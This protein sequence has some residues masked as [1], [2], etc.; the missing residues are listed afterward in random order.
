MK[1]LIPLF[2]LIFVNYVSAAFVYEDYSVSTE[3]IGGNGCITT[4]DFQMT[5]ELIKEEDLIIDYANQ[6][7]R[8][9]GMTIQVFYSNAGLGKSQWTPM[10]TYS[11]I[12]IMPSSILL[13]VG[14]WVQ[15]G[16]EKNWWI[17]VVIVDGKKCETSKKNYSF[18][19]D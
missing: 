7:I 2:F 8:Q 4:V 6:T 13:P 9:Q 18:E 15:N 10:S 11:G 12:Y 19:E 16:M 1:K 5:D 3:S 17:R 14:R